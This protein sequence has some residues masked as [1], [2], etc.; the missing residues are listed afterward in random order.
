MNRPGIIDEDVD[1]AGNAFGLVG[2][3]EHRVAIGEVGR[4]FPSV[5]PVGTHR[6]GSFRRSAGARTCARDIRTRFR[7]SERHRT[8]KAAACARDQRPLAVQRKQ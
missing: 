2:E 8:T 4:Q 3:C 5:S 7:K 6:C 1:R